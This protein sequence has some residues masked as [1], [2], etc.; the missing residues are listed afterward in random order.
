[1]H[2]YNSTHYC[3]DS[4]LY[5]PLPPDQHHISDVA[6]EA[7]KSSDS[8]AL[9]QIP[10]K[11]ARWRRWSVSVYGPVHHLFTSLLLPVPHYTAWRLQSAKN[12]LNVF[13]Q[14]HS[15][16]ALQSHTGAPCC[17]SCRWKN[18]TYSAELN[19]VNNSNIYDN[20]NNIYYITLLYINKK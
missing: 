4:F 18:S 3:R 17:S 14:L 16:W 9:S 11:A 12:L 8:S 6:I 20:P 7:K 13:M 15:G 2:H 10:T 1:V 5:I 19:N